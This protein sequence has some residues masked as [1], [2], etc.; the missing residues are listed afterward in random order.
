MEASKLSQ[1]RS[2][3]PN[4]WISIHGTQT[5]GFCGVK[6]WKI[7]HSSV[8]MSG[9]HHFGGH[10]LVPTRTCSKRCPVPGPSRSW[11]ASRLRWISKM[12]A[13][14]RHRS[15]WDAIKIPSRG[16][17]MPS[18]VGTGS[19]S[20][21]RAKNIGSCKWAAAECQVGSPVPIMSASLCTSLCKWEGVAI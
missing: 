20:M 19:S 16:P 11:Q 3:C 14:F 5:V 13:K 8:L 10:K 9:T 21:F 1:R 15:R 17:T 7:F 4:I 12:V 6:K 2:K 18:V